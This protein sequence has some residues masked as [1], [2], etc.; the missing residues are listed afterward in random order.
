MPAI[1]PL[2]PAPV[3]VPDTF[4]VVPLPVV[5]VVPV[6]PLVKVPVTCEA[7]ATEVPRSANAANTATLTIEFLML[8]VI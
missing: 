7:L 4:P 5:T 2:D 8:Y 3:T 6:E 1:D